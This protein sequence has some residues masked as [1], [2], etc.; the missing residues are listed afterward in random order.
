MVPSRKASYTMSKNTEVAITAAE[1]K[2]FAAIMAFHAKT[3]D[4]LRE[5][6]AVV[7][8]PEVMADAKSYRAERLKF[9]TWLVQERKIG[10]DSARVEVYR[11]LNY[12]GLK[13]PGANSGTANGSTAE[14]SVKQ[15]EAAAIVAQ[16]KAAFISAL[17]ACW[18]A[19]DDARAARIIGAWR[20]KLKA[21]RAWRKRN[22]VEQAA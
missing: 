20:E 21:S 19:E 2:A 12:A 8:T 7:F 5:L 17:G 15:V 3:A 4:K 1:S 10:V 6:C 11:I 14:A 22:M 9:Q 18:D 16:G 13:T